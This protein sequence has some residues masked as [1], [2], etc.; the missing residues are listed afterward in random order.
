M[1]KERLNNKVSEI[2]DLVKNYSGGKFTDVSVRDE[3]SN[4]TYID[5]NPI[6]IKCVVFD[7]D[8]DGNRVCFAICAA[9]FNSEER[10]LDFN[11]E[12]VMPVH[13]CNELPTIAAMS[14]STSYIICAIPSRIPDE[15]SNIY[16]D[17]SHMAMPYNELS[18]D[19]IKKYA[20]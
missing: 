18:L 17:Y 5:G 3:F 9:N 13:K 2:V 8:F 6:N 20:V 15:I 14:N 19:A 16:R 1:N 10:K 4:I 11:I 12:V 7:A